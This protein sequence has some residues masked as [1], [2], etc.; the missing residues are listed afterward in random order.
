M[1]DLW[2]FAISIPR[3]G[4]ISYHQLDYIRSCRGIADRYITSVLRW[5]LKDATHSFCRARTPAKFRL[6]ANGISVSRS[7]RIWNLPLPQCEF[8]CSG[9]SMRAVDL[10]DRMQNAPV[11]EEMHQQI[12]PNGNIENLPTNRLKFGIDC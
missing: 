5:L 6:V 2:W 9:R 7:L 10:P 4:C 11:Y 12:Q 8:D 1:S 3:P